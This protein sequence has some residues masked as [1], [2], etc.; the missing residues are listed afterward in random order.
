MGLS[1]SKR[2]I[3]ACWTGELTST[4]Q[5]YP[6]GS[7]SATLAADRNRLVREAVAS[8]RQ[9]PG[10][11][12]TEARYLCVN[13]SAAESVAAVAQCEAIGSHELSG[14]D[15]CLGRGTGRHR[16]AKAGRS[17]AKAKHQ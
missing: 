14:E 13:R 3:L 1:R 9:Q 7:C 8:L 11:H 5:R 4:V 16:N 12:D 6:S 2:S 10:A 15:V 17:C